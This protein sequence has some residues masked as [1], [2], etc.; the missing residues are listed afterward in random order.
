MNLPLSLLKSSHRALWNTKSSIKSAGIQLSTAPA[1]GA[2]M[3]PRYAGKR[4]KNEP[5]LVK[6]AREVGWYMKKMNTPVD[7]LGLYLDQW[8]V[9]EIKNPDKK[10]HA[11]EFTDDEIEFH[12]MI[13]DRGGKVLIWRTEKDVIRDSRARK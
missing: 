3:M 13:K 9:I 1:I 12:A 5:G 10:G 4:D 7:W 8:Q 2:E 11:D 6:I